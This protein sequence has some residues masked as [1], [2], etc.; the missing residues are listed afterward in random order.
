MKN[1][2]NEKY[3]LYDMQ[4][5]YGTK[6]STM[7]DALDFCFDLHFETR[8]KTSY[9]LLLDQKGVLLAHFSIFY[10]NASW[11]IHKIQEKKRK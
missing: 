6:F 1:E 11:T 4:E 5:E 2:N 9:Y 10:C 3:E 8:I 7:E